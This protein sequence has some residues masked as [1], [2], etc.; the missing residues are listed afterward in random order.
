[1]VE[2]MTADDLGRFVAIEACGGGSARKG[3]ETESDLE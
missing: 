2:V 3:F 1:V